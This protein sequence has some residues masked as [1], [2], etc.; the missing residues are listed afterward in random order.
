MQEELSLFRAIGF[1]LALFNFEHV[2]ERRN[3][4]RD[5]FYPQGVCGIFYR[6]AS[7]STKFAV[8]YCYLLYAP[9]FYDFDLRA[10]H[11]RT[12][13]PAALASVPFGFV[14]VRVRVRRKTAEENRNILT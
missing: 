5:T 12:L 4:D 10:S 7:L 8:S 11:A 9:P 1:L 2:A 3:N 14:L 13:L 6:S